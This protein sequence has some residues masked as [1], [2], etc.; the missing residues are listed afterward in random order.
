[1]LFIVMILLIVPGRRCHLIWIPTIAATAH[2]LLMITCMQSVNPSQFRDIVCLKTIGKVKR[3]RK[4]LLVAVDAVAFKS[5]LFRIHGYKRNEGDSK[6]PNWVDKAAIVHCFD[7]AMS[8]WKQKE[9]TCR[10][11]FKSSLL[12]VINGLY[13]VG[14]RISCLDN[15]HL[16]GGHVPVEVYNEKIDKTIFPKQA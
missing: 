11:H 12:V 3:D 14:E 9:S 7:P 6:S 5:Q 2:V 10:A 1:M 16:C 8:E 15:S 4:Y 13:V